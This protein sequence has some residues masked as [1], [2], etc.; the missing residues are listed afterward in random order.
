MKVVASACCLERCGLCLLFV[1]IVFM[2][3][4][5]EGRGVRL[6]FVKAVDGA[7]CL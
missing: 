3:A 2:P 6:L 5:C 1:K 4:V 7:C